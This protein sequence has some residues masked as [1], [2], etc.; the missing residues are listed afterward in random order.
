MI[1][2]FKC[3]ETEKVF[4]MGLFHKFSAGILKLATIPILTIFDK[5]SIILVVGK[6]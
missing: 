4:E 1:E 3:K 2:T 5:S 6:V